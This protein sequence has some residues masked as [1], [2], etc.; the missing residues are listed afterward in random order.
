MREDS[1]PI[2]IRS[3]L[4]P[5]ACALLASMVPWV[6]LGSHV[7]RMPDLV[8]KIVT[9]I[10]GS[11]IGVPGQ[12][13]FHPEVTTSWCVHG[14]H[15]DAPHGATHK[16]CLYLDEGETGAGV[17]FRGPIE[18]AGAGDE[19]LAPLGSIVLFPIGMEHRSG[20]RRKVLG[21]RATMLGARADNVPRGN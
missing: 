21:L 17:V 6:P 11:F 2:V 3:A 4:A 18:T 9:A 10:H 12:L 20:E 14:W 16:V 1:A 8:K 15:R 13:S 5:E 19:T 7:R